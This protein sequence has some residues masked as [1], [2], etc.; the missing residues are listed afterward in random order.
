MAGGMTAAGNLLRESTPA[1]AVHCLPE[2]RGG[3]RWP[4]ELPPH[5]VNQLCDPNT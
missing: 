2:P 4:L 3:Q 5:R 1:E